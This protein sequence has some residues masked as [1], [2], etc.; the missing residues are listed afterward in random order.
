MLWHFFWRLSAVCFSATSTCSTHPWRNSSPSLCWVWS[1]YATPTCTAWGTCGSWSSTCQSPPSPPASSSPANY[2]TEPVTVGS[3]EQRAICR[4]SSLRA[5]GENDKEASG[6]KMPCGFL[7]TS[8]H[9]HELSIIMEKSNYKFLVYN[10]YLH[11]V[12][13]FSETGKVIQWNAV[14]SVSLKVY[15]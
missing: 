1:S 3:E 15:G 6:T 4:A 8:N 9:I 7:M 11:F 13:I 12:Y 5:L 2:T 10:T 14:L